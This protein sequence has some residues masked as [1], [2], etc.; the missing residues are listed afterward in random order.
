[1]NRRDKA[2]EFRKSFD[3]MKSTAP[4]LTDL[5]QKDADLTS[6]LAHK[7]EQEELDAVFSQI[8][9]LIANAIAGNAELLGIRIGWDGVTY[10]TAGDAVRSIQQFMTEENENWSVI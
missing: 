9:D 1:M 8:D 10:P 5:E 3:D 7:A 4:R 2:E 6:Q